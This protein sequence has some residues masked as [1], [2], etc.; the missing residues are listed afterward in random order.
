[1]VAPVVKLVAPVEGLTVTALS[2]NVVPHRPVEVAVIVADPLKA[3]SQFINPE[4]AFITP[5]ATGDT[6]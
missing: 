5:A 1:M 3:A 2:A 6:E 4:F